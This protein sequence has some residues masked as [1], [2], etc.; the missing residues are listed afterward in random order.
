MKRRGFR[1]DRLDIDALFD[2][3]PYF[4]LVFVIQCS[5]RS[6]GPNDACT[7]I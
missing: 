7:F 1:W 6:S 3:L 5:R 4:Y 2:D